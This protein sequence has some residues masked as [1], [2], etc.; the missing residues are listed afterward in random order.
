MKT[1]RGPG[2]PPGSDR[3]DAVLRRGMLDAARIARKARALLEKRLRVL[4]TSETTDV[5]EIIAILQALDRSVEGT[6]KLLVRGV[7]DEELR[8][9][10]SPADIV[11]EM[12]KGQGGTK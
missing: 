3:P 8:E 6:G 11:A 9:T 12:Q 2:R 10:K 7:K 1:G 5:D 4:E